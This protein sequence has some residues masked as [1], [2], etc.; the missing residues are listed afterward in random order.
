MEHERGAAAPGARVEHPVGRAETAEGVHDQFGLLV[1]QPVQFGEDGLLPVLPGQVQHGVVEVADAV[2]VVDQSV[3]GTKEQVD[4]V[5]LFGVPVTG[6][7]RLIFVG[8]HQRVAGGAGA[9]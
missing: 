6:H 2:V 5:V 9:H 8:D 7:R 1:F 4:G 3:A